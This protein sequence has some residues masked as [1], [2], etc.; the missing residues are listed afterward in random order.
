MNS[1]IQIRLMT[2][3]DIPFAHALRQTAGWNQTAE[4]WRRFLTISPRGCFVAEW[5]GRPVGT[6]IVVTYDQDLAWIGMVLVEP[7][8]RN[9]GI[10]K[11]LLQHAVTTLQE[12]G[13][14][15]LKLDATP[16]GEPVYRSLGFQPEWSLQRW[17]GPKV[18]AE[19]PIAQLGV[20]AWKAEDLERFAALDRKAFGANRGSL[21][22]AL[23]TES[24]LARTVEGSGSTGEGF[25]FVRRGSR[26][27]YLGPVVGG[28]ADAGLHVI[29]VLLNELSASAVYWDIPEPNEPARRWAEQ[30]GFVPERRLTRMFLGPNLNPGDPLLQFALAAPELG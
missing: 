14:R 18:P 20:R 13:I 8:F 17:L 1:S 10:G 25:G 7:D 16:L 11:A 3:E 22:A 15:C 12:R 5:A 28:T 19:T 2:E 29:E 23:G 4:D 27:A 26:M 21:L 6:T 24:L 9:R 30:H